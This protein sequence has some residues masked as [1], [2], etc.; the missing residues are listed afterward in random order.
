MTSQAPR[1]CL[2]IGGSDPSGGAGIQADLKTFEAW[3]TFGM[4]VLTLITA[5]NTQGVQAVELL[6]TDIVKAQLRSIFD[7]FKIDAG[8]VGALGGNSIIEAVADVLDTR[9]PPR[10]VLDPV[11]ITKHGVRL[12]DASGERCLIER[13]IPHAHLITPN[14]A[15]ASVIFGETI[16]SSNAQ[17]AAHQLSKKHN[18]AVLITGGAA[19]GDEVADWFSD[20][21]IAKRFSHPRVTGPHQHGAGCTLSAAI[22]A[23]LAHGALLKDAIPKAREYVWNGMRLAPRIGH[24]EGP[25]QHRIEP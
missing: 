17:D 12:F 8:K 7:D 3:R 19:E 1:I 6:S 24:G 13:M 10:L 9:T 14:L 21:D 23:A 11:M 18:V 20:G 5:Q 2:T 25:L 16:T 22:A 15:E 4:S